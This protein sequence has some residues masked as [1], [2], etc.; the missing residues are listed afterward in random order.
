MRQLS[1]CWHAKMPMRNIHYCNYNRKETA[2]MAVKLL[3]TG[4]GWTVGVHTHFLIY[5]LLFCWIFLNKIYAL[6]PYL[7]K[8]TKYY[9]FRGK[10]LIFIWHPNKSIRM[11]DVFLEDIDGKIS[12]WNHCR[13]KI[14]VKNY[15]ILTAI[16]CPKHHCAAWVDSESSGGGLYYHRGL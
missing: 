15:R 4:G 14:G 5:I 9:L 10:I 7:K 12:L 16:L 8:T 11:T 1:M 13:L 6:L 3:A 2:E